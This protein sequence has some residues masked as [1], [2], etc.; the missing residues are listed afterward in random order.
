[1]L[2][3][4]DGTYIN[5]PNAGA[6]GGYLKLVAETVNE[7]D[8]PYDY[9]KFFENYTKFDVTKDGGYQAVVSIADMNEILT[10]YAQAGS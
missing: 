3:F 4:K 1:M 5:L 8:N 7:K 9:I 6:Y 10:E 2:E